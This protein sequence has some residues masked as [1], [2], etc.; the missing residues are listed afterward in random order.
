[1]ILKIFSF[2]SSVNNEGMIPFDKILLIY[3][4]KFSSTICASFK[5]KTVFIF[6]KPI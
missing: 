2:T 5:I 3:S 6:F 4:R 1:M